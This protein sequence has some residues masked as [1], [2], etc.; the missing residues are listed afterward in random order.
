MQKFV[1]RS[2]KYAAG[3]VGIARD[4]VGIHHWTHAVE[5]RYEITVLG[6]VIKTRKNETM[7]LYVTQHIGWCVLQTR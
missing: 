2:S 3:K 5:K 7:E 6:I 4:G 1:L